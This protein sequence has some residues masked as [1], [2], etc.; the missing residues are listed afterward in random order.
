MEDNEKKP[1]FFFPSANFKLSNVCKNN[2][3]ELNGTE[4]TSFNLLNSSNSFS[5]F[6]WLTRFS[7]VIFRSSALNSLI[8]QI[9]SL[10]LRIQ[11]KKK[12]KYYIKFYVLHHSSGPYQKNQKPHIPTSILQLYIT[13][14]GCH[15]LQL[16]KPNH[17]LYVKSD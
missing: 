6:A 8:N 3:V 14:L 15:L 11:R 10:E 7:T 9:Q 17:H 1:H 2:G 5:F 4:I 12:K 13:S 16:T